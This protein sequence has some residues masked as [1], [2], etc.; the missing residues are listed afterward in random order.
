VHDLETGV[1]SY[2]V[3]SP[4][5][6]MLPSAHGHVLAHVDKELIG[7]NWFYDQTTH[8]ELYDLETHIYRQV[9][10]IAAPY[11]GVARH[12]KWLAWLYSMGTIFLCDLEA[13][14]FMGADGHLLPEG[15]IPDAGVGDAGMDGGK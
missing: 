11:F 14:G 1:N 4:Y 2:A 8:V 5:D 6:Q 3:M 9:T 12:G 10:Q 13:G 7:D 15:Y